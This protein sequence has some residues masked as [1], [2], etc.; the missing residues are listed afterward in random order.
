MELMAATNPTYDLMVLL[1]TAAPDE[2]RK[3]VLSDTESLIKKQGEIIGTHD[4]GVRPTAYEIDKKTD[5][6]YHLV[7]FHAT[8]EL[9]ATLDR[10]LRITDGVL[11]F[12]I[13]KL[14]PGTPGPPEPEAPQAVAAAAPVSAPAPSAPVDAPDEQVADEP[15]AD[16]PVADDQPV[17]EPPP[18]DEQPADEPSADEPSADEPS[19]DEPAPTS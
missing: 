3:K 14:A 18:V 7:Q 13:I 9:L 19:V 2:Q 10:T 1:D 15:V 8:A 5:A 12:R 17:A 4:W 11:R 16:Q 6:D